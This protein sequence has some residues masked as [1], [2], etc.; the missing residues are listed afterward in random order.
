MEY[1]KGAFVKCH[2]DPIN[3]C[4]VLSEKRLGSG[5]YRQDGFYLKLSKR[6]FVLPAFY[7]GRNP[8][9][10]LNGYYIGVPLNIVEVYSGS[11]DAMSQLNYKTLLYQKCDV[12]RI[13]NIFLEDER[14]M[15][16]TKKERGYKMESCKISEFSKEMLLK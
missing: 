14:V 7:D 11:G 13:C 9:R 15:I 4:E 1:L 10:S 2:D 12:S 6:D 5:H 3:K 16:I 8:L